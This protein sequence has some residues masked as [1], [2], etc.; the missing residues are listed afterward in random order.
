MF[1]CV[2]AIMF[3][4]ATSASASDIAAVVGDGAAEGSSESSS[5]CSSS[6]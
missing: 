4:R 1:S 5:G 3:A 6:R 2:L